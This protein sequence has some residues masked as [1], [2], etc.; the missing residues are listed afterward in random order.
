M[1]WHPDV[2][3]KRSVR[4]WFGAERFRKGSTLAVLWVSAVKGHPLHCIDRKKRRIAVLPGWVQRYR[5]RRRS[6]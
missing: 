3:L 5:P 4:G 6:S 2:R 1:T